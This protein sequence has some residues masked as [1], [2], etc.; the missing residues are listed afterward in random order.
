VKKVISSLN[1]IHF[2]GINFMAFLAG[3][4]VIFIMLTVSINVALRYFLNHPLGWV[5]EGSEYA[6]LYI[7]FLGAAWLLKKEGHVKMSVILDL[8]K[9][10]AQAYVNVIN[11]II[12]AIICCLLVW[13]GTQGT[14]YTLQYN[15]L[16]VRYLSLPKFVFLAIIPVGSFFLFTQS[17]KRTHVYLQ[18]LKKDS[19]TKDDLPD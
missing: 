19:F 13:Y 3:I 17:V 2:R 16:S 8:L 1:V 5:L 4:L 7:T 15:I 11:S 12:M 6:L 14:L 18:L 10:R 9:P